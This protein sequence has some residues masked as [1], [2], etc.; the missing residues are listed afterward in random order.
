M[1]KSELRKMIK[2]ELLREGT[3]EASFEDAAGRMEM[4]FDDFINAVIGK[5]G[6][7]GHKD[8]KA[9]ANDLTKIKKAFGN[10]MSKYE[11]NDELWFRDLA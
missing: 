7:D 2:E 4:L 5:N 1:K 11:D 10:A 9:I 6:Y 8:G 3:S